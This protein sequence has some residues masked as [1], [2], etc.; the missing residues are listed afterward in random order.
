MICSAGIKDD[1][2]ILA[3]A[4]NLV[5]VEARAAQPHKIVPA[6]DG[7][8]LGDLFDLAPLGQHIARLERLGERVLDAGDDDVDDLSIAADIFKLMIE[9][10]ECDRRY[11]FGFI[12][13]KLDL[14]FRGERMDHVR[15]RA[16]K[17]DRI[18]HIDRLRAVRQGDRH[19]VVFAHA[20]GL[21]RAG[22]F[23]DLADH[24]AIACR[25]AHE[26]KGRAVGILLG[27]L[28]DRVEHR[29]FKIIQMQGDVLGMAIPG[30][31]GS[32]L[33]HG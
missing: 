16:D 9:L 22:A 25:A 15:D 33:F 30:R 10:I 14:L 1:G 23:F 2:R 7:S 31:F 21:E 29:S 18:E 32:D 8:F 26:S 28:L 12:E 4:F 20:D 13:V 24:L 6:D 5:V 19:L 17:V 11:A 3:A 27:G